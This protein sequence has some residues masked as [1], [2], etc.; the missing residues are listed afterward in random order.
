MENQKKRKSKSI[1]YVL[2]HLNESKVK[3]LQYPKNNKKEYIAVL[4]YGCKTCGKC[5]AKSKKAKS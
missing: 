2:I 4:V 1:V 5:K 3:K